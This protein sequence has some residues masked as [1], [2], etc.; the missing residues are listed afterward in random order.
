MENYDWSRFVLKIPVKSTIQQ[1]FDAWNSPAALESWFL[2]R[3]DFT[4]E[5][6]EQRAAHSPLEKGDE[7]SWYWHG[8]T[9]ESAEHGEIL[10][11]NGHD[12]LQFLFGKAGIVTVRISAAEGSTIVELQQESIPL[13]ETSR[14]NYYIGCSNGWTFYLANLK[15][16][17]EG[18]L[19]LRNKN[20]ALQQVVNS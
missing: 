12:Y 14:V 5:A 7:F 10:A 4:N 8:F 19:D 17:L 1:A 6:G 18:G 16:L 13:D 11:T 20:V 2:R 9:D 3:A 15:S